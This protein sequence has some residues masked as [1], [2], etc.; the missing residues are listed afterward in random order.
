MSL[1]EGGQII[2]TP[3]S[4]IAGRKKGKQL[5]PLVIAKRSIPVPLPNHG[6]NG[7]LGKGAVDALLPWI[8]GNLSPSLCC[9]CCCCCC[10]FDYL[11]AHFDVKDL[12]LQCKQK[13]NNI[14][15]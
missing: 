1:L 2:A 13:K 11:N 12:A 6:N 7:K 5:P 8:P 10:F 3:G 4:P 9:S 14:V 15:H